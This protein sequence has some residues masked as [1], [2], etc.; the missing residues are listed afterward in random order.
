MDL[1]I[2]LLHGRGQSSGNSIHSCPGITLII[3]ITNLTVTKERM[4]VVQLEMLE[5]MLVMQLEQM[6]V[7]Q[8]H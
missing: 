7:M 8:L 4:L 3:L 2:Q 6:A 1:S 5:Q